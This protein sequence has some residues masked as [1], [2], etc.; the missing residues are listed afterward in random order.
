MAREKPP[1]GCQRGN[2]EEADNEYPV[3]S[4]ARSADRARS[5]PFSSGAHVGGATVLMIESLVFTWVHG[6]VRR[7]HTPITLSVALGLLI[8]FV[9][10]GRM[11]LKPIF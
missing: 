11:V 10:F 4:S 8:T 2:W 3:G 1:Y 7:E 6:Q 5:P 9:V